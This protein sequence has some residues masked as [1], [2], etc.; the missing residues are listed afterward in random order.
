MMWCAPNLTLW[1]AS[2]QKSSS[3]SSVIEPFSSRAEEEKGL[4]DSQNYLAEKF[5]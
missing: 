4:T 1:K 2:T 5:L 3:V